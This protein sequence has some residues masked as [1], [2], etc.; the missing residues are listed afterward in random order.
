MKLHELKVQRNKKDRS[1]SHGR[2]QPLSQRN[3]LYE[4][5]QKVTVKNHHLK[6]RINDL[7]KEL[8]LELEDKINLQEK[9]SEIVNHFSLAS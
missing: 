5:L 6:Q 7:E 8:H 4:S 2:R 3:D 1:N 9:L